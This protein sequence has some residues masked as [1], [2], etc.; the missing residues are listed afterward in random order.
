MILIQCRIARLMAKDY[1]YLG[2]QVDDNRK[3]NYKRG[4]RPYEILSTQGWQYCD[5][6]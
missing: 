1:L 6:S 5:N 3:M 2:Y 4:Y